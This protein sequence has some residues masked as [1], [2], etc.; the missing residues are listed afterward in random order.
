MAKGYSGQNLEA[1]KI[2]K[3]EASHDFRALI[4]AAALAAKDEG[5]SDAW[6]VLSALSTDISVAKKL[7]AVLVSKR[8]G[9]LTF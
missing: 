4:Q 2:R 9:T 5:F 7:K 1:N 6:S 3:Q 8:S